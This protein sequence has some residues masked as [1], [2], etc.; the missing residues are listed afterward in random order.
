M[1]TASFALSD[2][3]CEGPFLIRQSAFGN[4]KSATLKVAQILLRLQCRGATHSR[5]RDGLLVNAVRYVTGDEDA[6]MFT[7]DQISRDQITVGIHVEFV[8]ISLCIRIMPDRYEN[9]RH[10]QLAFVLRFEVAQ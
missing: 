5:S 10:F 3:P 4:R 2:P 9:A 8:S 1:Q 7:L 6:G